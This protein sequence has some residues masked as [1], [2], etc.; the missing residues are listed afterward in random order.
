MRFF[1]VTKIARDHLAIPF[2]HAALEIVFS[3]GGD[4]II[5][6]QNKITGGTL[7]QIIYLK[8]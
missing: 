6:K 8:D 1:I 4:I 2:I 5:K 3:E 7:R